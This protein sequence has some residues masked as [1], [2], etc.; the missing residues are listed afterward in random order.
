ML[1]EKMKGWENMWKRFSRLV[2][3]VITFMLGGI[4]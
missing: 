1:M 2:V 4:I 3:G